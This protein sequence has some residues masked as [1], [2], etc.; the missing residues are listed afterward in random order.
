MKDWLER[1]MQPWRAWPST[2]SCDCG[3]TYMITVHGKYSN[4]DLKRMIVASASHDGWH[5]VDY[6]W[7][8]PSCWESA[9]RSAALYYHTGVHGP[10]QSI[11]RASQRRNDRIRIEVQ[12]E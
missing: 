3:E 4:A 7:T 10:W 8:C 1:K 11:Y 12:G 6:R 2:V 9:L 5:E